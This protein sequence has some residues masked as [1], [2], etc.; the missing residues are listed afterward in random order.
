MSTHL[1][2]ISIPQ[3]KHVMLTH[4]QSAGG[5]AGRRGH[6]LATAAAVS[7]LLGSFVLL[8][9]CVAAPGYDQYA[10]AYPYAYPSYGYFAFNDFDDFGDFDDFHRHRDHFD[11]H[12]FDHD[13]DHHF[14]GHGDHWGHAHPGPSLWPFMGSGGPRR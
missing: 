5:T 8:S 2:S 9:G 10:G 1:T 14:D 4:V 13:H 11:H 3:G 12:R 7:L 6:R